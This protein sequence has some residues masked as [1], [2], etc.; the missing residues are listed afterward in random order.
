MDN[1]QQ[2]LSENWA[3]AMIAAVG[4]FVLWTLLRASARQGLPY[5][6]RGHL[7]TRN[8]L[9]FFRA[10]KHAVKDRWHI[11]A[12]V[13]I[14]DLLQVRSGTPKSISWFNRIACKHVDFVLCDPDSL[15]PRLAIEL[16]DDSHRRP[17]R[18]RA[19]ISSTWH[20]R[21]PSFPWSASPPSRIMTSIPSA[22]RCS[23]RW[24]CKRF[25]VPA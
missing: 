25:V 5:S 11:M 21:R 23:E 6:R 7:V 3:W 4:A 18:Q 8:E 17:D 13:R 2:W 22:Q 12:M 9:K 19:M 24:D 1:L 15:E 14:A 20:S 16:D 10:L